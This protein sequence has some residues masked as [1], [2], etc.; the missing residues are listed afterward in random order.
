MSVFFT[1]LNTT[2]EFGGGVQ[3]NSCPRNL[4]T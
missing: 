2:V 4:Q 3:S 1:L